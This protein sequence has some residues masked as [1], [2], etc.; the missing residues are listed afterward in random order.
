MSIGLSE[1]LWAAVDRGY[2]LFTDDRASEEFLML[3]LRRGWQRLSADSLLREQL[4]VERSFAASFAE[5]RLSAWTLC[6]KAPDVWKRAGEMDMATLIELRRSSEDADTL[7]VFRAGVASLAEDDELWQ[8]QDFQRFRG[9]AE[10]IVTEQIEPAWMALEG[11]TKPSAKGI[12]KVFDERAAISD[13]VR[14]APELF[15][16]SPAASTGATAAA[17]AG[18]HLVVPAL[19]ALGCGIAATTVGGI[20]GDSQSRR[21]DRRAS[22]YLSYVHNLAARSER[23]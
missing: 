4:G 3:R 12:L 20:I 23:S 22:Q 5:A 1:A 16:R 11:K 18:F 19:L 8:A 13:T 15:I 14:R 6:L 21:A 2:T 10:T 17:L 9:R 7:A